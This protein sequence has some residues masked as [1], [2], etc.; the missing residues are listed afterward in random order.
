MP[1]ASA[2]RTKAGRMNPPR[3]WDSPLIPALARTEGALAR[4]K[5]RADCATAP[6]LT[7]A[8]DKAA[9]M[10]SFLKIIMLPTPE[11]TAGAAVVETCALATH[12]VNVTGAQVTGLLTAL[13]NNR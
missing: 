3:M 4:L 12:Q 8:R 1:T 6:V 2:I 5:G 9:A 10:P 11:C 7:V 13:S